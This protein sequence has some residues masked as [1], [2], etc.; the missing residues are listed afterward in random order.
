MHTNPIVSRKRKGVQPYYALPAAQMV[1]FHAAQH[2]TLV[3][4]DACG[5]VSVRCIS[6]TAHLTTCWAAPV[7][8][9]LAESRRMARSAGD[10]C[11]SRLQ[12]AGDACWPCGSKAPMSVWRASMTASISRFLAAHAPG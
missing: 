4:R 7:F 12:S 6:T 11:S 2:Q 9:D 3:D 10:A 5:S 8:G 1:G